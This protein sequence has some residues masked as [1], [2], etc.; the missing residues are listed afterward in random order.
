MS[1]TV[2]LLAFIGCMT[3]IGGA[4]YSTAPEDA[5]QAPILQ[6]QDVNIADDRVQVSY[7]ILNQSSV[8]LWVCDDVDVNSPID[9]EAV[10]DLEGYALFVRLRLGLELGWW[11][12]KPP[13]ARYI[14]I[15][16]NESYR[17]LIWMTLPVRQQPVFTSRSAHHPEEVKRAHRIVLEVGYF[18]G[19]LPHRIEG[20]LRQAKKARQKQDREWD[21]IFSEQD[22]LLEKM[23]RILEQQERLTDVV[24][25]PLSAELKAIEAQMRLL[26]TAMDSVHS[27]KLYLEESHVEVPME[28]LWLVEGADPSLSEGGCDIILDHAYHSEVERERFLRAVVDDIVLPYVPPRYLDLQN[29]RPWGKQAVASNVE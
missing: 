15:G 11:R 2:A 20:F 6:I 10:V 7:A 21:Q 4:G 27:L 24:E 14:C 13:E 29:T 1:E 22:R 9:F 19:D 28:T 12:S 8:D 17:G 3:G 5:P 25:G 16:P 18:A 23:V 26:D